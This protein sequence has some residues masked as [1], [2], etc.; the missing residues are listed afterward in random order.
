[1]S[2]VYCGIASLPAATLASGSQSVRCLRGQ[3]F[4]YMH[5]TYL[6]SKCMYSRSHSNVLHIVLRSD[7]VNVENIMDEVWSNN[8]GAGWM[9]TT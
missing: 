1:M 5:S 2:R 8:A 6:F 4:I 3:L 7:A 9:F